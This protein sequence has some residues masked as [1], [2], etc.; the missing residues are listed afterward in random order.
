MLPITSAPR[1]RCR[2]SFSRQPVLCT[3]QR[4]TGDTA[5]HADLPCRAAMHMNNR[6]VIA[7][8]RSRRALAA[9]AILLALTATVVFG[10][11]RLPP[12]DTVPRVDLNR[13]LGS[14]YEIAGIPN[15]FQKH[16]RTNTMARYARRDD[17]RI[18]VINRCRDAKG[19]T[20]VAQGV[21]RIVDSRSNAKLEVSFVSLFGWQLFWGDYWILDLAPDYAYA[22]VGTPD[23]RYGWILSRT[24]ALDADSR[25][26]IDARLRAAGYDPGAFVDTPQLHH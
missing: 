23:R 4:E 8:A 11:D 1:R 20:D 25:K 22:I 7:V 6:P 5:R 26:R 24:P 16:C 10:A 15:R 18:E 9:A 19:D 3:T 12:P 2:V 21:A 14:W 17:G 13:Y